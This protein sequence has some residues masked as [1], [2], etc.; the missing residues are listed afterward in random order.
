LHVALQ[1]TANGGAHVV[2]AIP[3]YATYVIEMRSIVNDVWG[4][5]IGGQIRLAC[6]EWNYGADNSIDC[7]SPAVADY[8]QEFLRMLKEQHVWLAIQFL[9]GSNGNGMDMIT[10]DGHPTAYYQAFKASSLGNADPTL[11]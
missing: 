4:S 5:G 10:I 8:Y 2:D 6:T 11:N 9:I 1:Y 7:S 3:R